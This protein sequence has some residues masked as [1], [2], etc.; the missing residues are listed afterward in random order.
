[1]GSKFFPSKIGKLQFSQSIRM[2]QTH[3][4]NDIYNKYCLTHNNLC[5]FSLSLFT[6]RHSTNCMVESNCF[7]GVVNKLTS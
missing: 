7:S 4:K 1:M 3:V 6:E 2:L 5:I